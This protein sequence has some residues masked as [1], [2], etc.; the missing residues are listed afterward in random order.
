MSD[1]EK[2]E[3]KA[4]KFIKGS[5]AEIL[6]AIVMLAA[7]F[8]GVD[9]SQEADQLQEIALR[10]VAVASAAAVGVKG[11]YNAAAALIDEIEDEFD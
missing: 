5:G 3:G 1:V 2:A 8:F 11:V 6:A 4:I 7:L 9:L 10:A